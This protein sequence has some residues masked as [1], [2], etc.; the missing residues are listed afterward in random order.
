VRL[1]HIHLEHNPLSVN[2]LLRYTEFAESRAQDRIDIGAVILSPAYKYICFLSFSTTCGEETKGNGKRRFYC[3][4]QE[5][6]PAE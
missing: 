5:I 6:A 3:P 2:F 1:N 4:S